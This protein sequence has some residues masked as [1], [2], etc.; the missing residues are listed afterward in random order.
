MSAP[1][2]Q[3]MTMSARAARQRRIGADREL[4]DDRIRSEPSYD[5]DDDHFLS[6]E[7]GIDEGAD[8]PPPLMAVSDDEGG[9]NYEEGDGSGGGGGGGGAS[10]PNRRRGCPTFDGAT[11]PDLDGLTDVE[12]KKAMLTLGR[13]RT[14]C[15]RSGRVTDEKWLKRCARMMTRHWKSCGRWPKLRGRRMAA[16]AQTFLR[17]SNTR[18]WRV[19]RAVYVN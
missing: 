15:C 1:G 5:D 16:I 8:D 10:N 19:V 12:A 9:D 11:V 4:D 17:G 2:H 3:P 14:G 7:E 13:R 6:D 18:R